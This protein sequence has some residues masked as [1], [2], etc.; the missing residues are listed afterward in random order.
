METTEDERSRSCKSTIAPRARGQCDLPARS[1]TGGEAVRAARGRDHGRL[2]SVIGNVGGGALLVH[3]DKD[4][5]KAAS[6][7]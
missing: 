5:P 2:V 7:G 1:V 6:F 4:A 3:T